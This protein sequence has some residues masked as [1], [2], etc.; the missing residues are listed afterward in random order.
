MNKDKKIKIFSRGG[1][2]EKANIAT[3]RKISE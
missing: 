1:A 2:G 3:K